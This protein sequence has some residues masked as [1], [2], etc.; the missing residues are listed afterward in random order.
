M[1]WVCAMSSAFSR[2]LLI[3]ALLSLGW[4][5]SFAGDAASAARY[6]ED[7]LAHFNEGDHAGAVI[8]LKNALQQDG[9]MLAAQVLLARALLE[10][11]EFPAADAAFAEAIELGVSPSEIAAPRGRLLLA[12]GRVEQLLQDIQADGL[13]GDD[14]V[15]VLTLRAKAQVI[16][17]RLDEARAAFEVAIATDR[18]S[19]RP[20]LELVPFLIQQ[21]DL[22]GAA[23]QMKRAMALGEQRA[24]VWNLRASL[25]HVQ[26]RLAAALADYSHALELDPGFVD[27]RVARASIFVDLDRRQQAREDLAYL[28]KHARREPRSAY[29]RAV[30]AGREGLREAVREALEEVAQLVDALPPEY[31]SA[32]EQ[33]LML[34]ALSHHGLKAAEKAKGYLATLLKRFPRNGGGH[35]LLAAIYLDEGNSPQALATLEPVLKAAPEDPQANLLAGRAQLGLKRY[36]QAG[37]SLDKAVRFLQ[38]DP[39]ALAALG[40]S[41]I[42]Q[43]LDEEGIASLERAML[44]SPADLAIG[45]VLASL[46]MKRADGD[47]ASKLAASLVE[48]NRGNPIARNL[49]G[50]V[51]AA[52]GD[53]QGAREQYLQALA[54]EPGYAPSLLNLARLE[55]GLG[56]TEAARSRLTKMLTD[57]PDDP[58]AMFELGRIARQQGR[59]DEALDWFDK[60]LAQDAGQRQVALAKVEVLSEAGRPDAA[61]AA[62][63]DMALRHPDDLLV[64]AVLAQAYLTLGDAKNARQVMRKMT[65]DA[66]FDEVA[67]VRIGRMR[68]AAGFATDAAYN[69]QKALAARPDYPPALALSFE[70]AMAGQKLDEA[71]EALQAMRRVAADSPDLPRFEGT[72]ALATGDGAKALEIFRRIYDDAPSARAALN[73][74]AVQR[75]LERHRDA[76]KALQAELQR[77]DSAEVR[78]ALAELQFATRQWQ[79]ARQSYELLLARSPQDPA[80]LNCMALVLLQLG[81]PAAL[82]TAERAKQ[83]LPRNAGVIDTVGWIK[84]K[85]GDVEGALPLLRDARLRE[86]QNPEIRF[87]LASA[88]ARSGRK[89]EARAELDVA[90]AGEASFVESAQALE[91]HRMLSAE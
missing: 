17:G 54:A 76:A 91:L 42:G 58:R 36:R 25:N 55:S 45:S 28:A 37:A 26:G 2:Q 66:E 65:R 71:R 64:E 81:D 50:S 70:S 80:L 40:A 15:E 34:G 46:Y 59:L 39:Q 60:A 18:A 85:Q 83:L 30:L 1:P 73:L 41:Y 12:L 13:R 32:N 48:H 4:G 20:Y 31:A 38:D 6:F 51:M 16:A 57:R 53:S 79:A 21:G 7:G 90:L 10:Q 75:Q 47:K 49:L 74:A 67:Q 19:V 43:G 89:G 27:A 62:A 23:A 22:K 3:A 24:E 8:Q 44:A 11:G 35:K 9:K 52:A 5:P 61:V 29:L 84:L 14:L 77:Q 87:H 82:S 88:L 72:L 63:K 69:V 78:R 68:L 33:L 86:P 56:Q